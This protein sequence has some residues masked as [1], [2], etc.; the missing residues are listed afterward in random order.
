MQI[1]TLTTHR[2]NKKAIDSKMQN[3]I[4]NQ[5]LNQKCHIGESYQ[6]THTHTT[7]SCKPGKQSHYNHTWGE[8]AAVQKKCDNTFQEL[9]VALK[10]RD[11]TFQ[12]TSCHAK[13]A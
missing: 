5:C 13:K 2:V 12:G 10:K 4:A 7:H 8:Q 6:G 1:H 3:C 11:N 9:A